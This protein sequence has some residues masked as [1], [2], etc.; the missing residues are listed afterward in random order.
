MHEALPLLHQQHVGDLRRLRSS[1][2]CTTVRTALYAPGP[3]GSTAS[4][5]IPVGAYAGTTVRCV[6]PCY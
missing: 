3:V 5:Q 1:A 4:E 2:V 6:F